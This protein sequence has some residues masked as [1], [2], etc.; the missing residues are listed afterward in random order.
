MSHA[1][2]VRLRS[3]DDEFRAARGALAFVLRSWSGLGET[4]ELVGVSI[5]A[6]RHAAI[7]VED[8]YVVRLVTEFERVLY[9]WWRD[10]FP[11]KRVPRTLWG[12]INRV[13][14]ARKVDGDI[15]QRAHDVREYRN[16]LAHVVLSRRPPMPIGEALSSLSRFLAWLPSTVGR[17]SERPKSRSR[18]LCYWSLD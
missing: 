12:L 3:V 2:I 10:S 1:H 13:A 4:E 6:A 11:A 17:H 5:P 7:R 16:H 18:L 9:D 8:T 15:V 14:T